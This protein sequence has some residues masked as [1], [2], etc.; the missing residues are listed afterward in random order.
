[1]LRI[2]QILTLKSYRISLLENSVIVY[3]FSDNC[4]SLWG[5]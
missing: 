1:M 5:V 3:N 2:I 4:L